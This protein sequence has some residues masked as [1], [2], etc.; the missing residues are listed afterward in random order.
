MAATVARV[1]TRVT[2]AKNPR[3]HPC[4]SLVFGAVTISTRTPASTRGSGT[5][6]GSG[7]GGVERIISG[8][9]GGGSNVTAGVVTIGASG[10]PDGG[11]AGSGAGFVR[12]SVSG[13]S[14][15]TAIAA[16]RLLRRRT[17]RMTNR[18]TTSVT[19]TAPPMSAIA[20]T[21]KG[22]PGWAALSRTSTTHWK[23]ALAD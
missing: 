11:E 1:N 4:S 18:S 9:G 8:G 16:Q 3:P 12:G 13:A 20:V 10:S 6:T 15:S 2:R 7:G 23:L 14:E 5:G 21:G 19:A 17:I 22:D